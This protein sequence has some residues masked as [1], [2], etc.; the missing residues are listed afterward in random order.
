MPHSDLL[1]GVT[2]RFCAPRVAC[3]PRP[4]IQRARRR[5]LLV[6]L[7][8]LML[9]ALVDAMLVRWPSAH[10]PFLTR[11]ES[12][13]LV[14]AINGLMIAFVWLTRAFPKWSAQRI[15]S[16]WCAAERNRL[17]SR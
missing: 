1:P 14:I 16:T 9:V 11:H 7:A 4:A 3:D 17:R 8:Q 12:I 10:V 2:E 6:D 13:V 5:A 15:A